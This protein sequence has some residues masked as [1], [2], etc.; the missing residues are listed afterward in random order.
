M[1]APLMIATDIANDDAPQIAG[2]IVVLD[3]RE[4]VIGDRLRPIDPVWAGALGQSMRR[5][6]QIHAIEVCRIDGRWHLAG[7]GGHRLTGAIA[8]GIPIE[9]RIVSSDPD[10]RRRRE[11]VENVLRRDNDPIERATAIA[12]LVRL[13]K[14]RAGIDPT[15]SGGAIA[16]QTRWQKAVAAEAVDANDTMSLAY[17]WS[18][19]V[20]AQIGFTKRTVER[21][22]M[23]YRRLPPSLID[24]LRAVRHPI[25]TNATQLRAL[26][27]LDDAGQQDRAVDLLLAG[28]ARTIGDAI[29]VVQN[30]PAPD[31]DAKLLSAFIGAFQRMSLA[32][33][34]GALV[35][36][37]P[38]IPAGT[39][40]S[41]AGDR[42]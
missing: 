7:P 28:A 31:R 18:Q 34:K 1:S 19:E 10:L 15:R 33:R 36:L 22:L 37:R 12:E 23:L 24:R 29:R 26:A 35:H 3:P 25:L 20:A 16:A 42:A 5:D 21:D 32:E 9:A 13:H 8:A 38:L 27:K 2:E 40:L 4:V 30:R 17:G 6:G 39:S 14:L 11:A 41:N